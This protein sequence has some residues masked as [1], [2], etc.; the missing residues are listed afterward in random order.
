MLRSLSFDTSGNR[1]DSEFL[2]GAGHGP[3]VAGHPAFA[4]PHGG[5]RRRRPIHRSR[6]RRLPEPFQQERSA[7]HRAR[8][9]GGHLRDFGYAAGRGG[10]EERHRFHP[11]DA[12]R[13]RGPDQAPLANALCHPGGFAYQLFPQP[14]RQRRLDRQSADRR[15]AGAR[16]RRPEAGREDCARHRGDFRTPRFPGR[17]RRRAEPQ[18]GDSGKGPAGGQGEGRRISPRHRRPGGESEI[19]DDRIPPRRRT[20]PQRF[21]PRRDRRRHGRAGTGRIRDDAGRRGP[22]VALAVGGRVHRHHDRSR[23]SCPR[24]ASWAGPG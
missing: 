24:S 16:R 17:P 12:V 1:D 20:L 18:P 19:S 11:R 6:R 8:R 3:P 22:D 13:R 9:F 7:P 5:S 14:G 4:G 21:G 15:R 2:H 23:F 10:A